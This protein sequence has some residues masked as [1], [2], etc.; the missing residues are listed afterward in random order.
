MDPKKIQDVKDWPTPENRKQVQHFPGFANFCREFIK[1]VSTIATLLQ[2][3]ISLKMSFSW[4]PQ[5]TKAFQFLKDCFTSVPVLILPDPQR[6]F[7]VEVDALDIGIGALLS[8]RDPVNGRLHPS[9]FLS[10]KL[11]SAEQ[12]YDTGNP[13][14]LAVKVALDEW[15]HWLEGAE[16]LFR[17]W[18]DHKNLEYLQTAETKF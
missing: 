12:N 17:V 11:S 4:S 18:T 5:A 14:L 7:V 16:L 9:A 6:Q 1:N 13:E 8:Q 10:R 2:A 15:R 3:L